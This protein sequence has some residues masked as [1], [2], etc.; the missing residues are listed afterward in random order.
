MRHFLAIVVS[1]VLAMAISIGA[2]VQFGLPTWIGT[3]LL[4]FLA[5]LFIAL[6]ART[7]YFAEVRDLRLDPRAVAV[8]GAAVFVGWALHEGGVV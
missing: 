8:L 6:L 7:P 1:I 5:L 3:F 4:F 2:Q